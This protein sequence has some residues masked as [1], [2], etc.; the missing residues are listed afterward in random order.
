MQRLSEI[1]VTAY[2]LLM[3]AAISAYADNSHPRG[4][5]FDGTIGNVGK[6]D[7]SGP[8]YKIKAEYGKQSGA[9]LFHSFQQF[10]LNI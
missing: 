4:I 2:L 1:I 10:N 3:Y 8:N 6:L 9:N 5:T 7:L